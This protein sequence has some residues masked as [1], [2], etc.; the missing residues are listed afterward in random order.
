M[1]VNNKAM[2]LKEIEKQNEEKRKAENFAALKKFLA[3]HEKKAVILVKRTKSLVKKE[4]KR[5]E[6]EIGKHDR[7]IETN[8]SKAQGLNAKNKSR[9]KTQMKR[10]QSRLKGYD[11]M[12]EQ[13]MAAYLR[14]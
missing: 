8:K 10:L 12:T 4:I 1:K 11:T 5:L 13:E 9:L 3:D 6:S 14:R 2:P 7:M